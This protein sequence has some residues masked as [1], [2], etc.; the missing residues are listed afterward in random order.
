[1]LRRSDQTNL[2]FPCGIFGASH[3]EVA[4]LLAV[5]LLY[6]RNR[7]ERG[8]STRWLKEG[9]LSA[10]GGGRGSKP[11]YGLLLNSHRRRWSYAITV[12]HKDK[13]PKLILNKEEETD[14]GKLGWEEG[15]ASQESLGA[16]EVDHGIREEM[17]EPKEGTKNIGTK[18]G[19]KKTL[20][21][22]E[23]AASCWGKEKLQD[24]QTSA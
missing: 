14:Q 11:H 6:S 3:D 19:E 23:I 22:K 7:H 12:L 5:N 13:W 4:L 8:A 17:S 2:A 20:A 1:M 24:P 16:G 15:N 9:R 21:K 18:L 10:H